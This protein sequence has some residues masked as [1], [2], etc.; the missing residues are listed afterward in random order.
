MY[1]GINVSN[2]MRETIKTLTIIMKKIKKC[3]LKST[4]M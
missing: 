4:T 2:L 3:P 1:F